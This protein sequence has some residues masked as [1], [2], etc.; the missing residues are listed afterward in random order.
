[1]LHGKENKGGSQAIMNPGFNHVLRP[2]GP[3]QEIEKTSIRT[4]LLDLPELLPG[5]GRLIRN[6]GVKGR[7]K[8]GVRT[9]F[10]E[11]LFDSRKRLAER[12]REVRENFRHRCLACVDHGVSFLRE[13]M[14]IFGSGHARVRRYVW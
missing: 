14:L 3:Y 7:K 4:Q 9:Q 5:K 6:Y 12:F 2:G 10:V 11:P 8:G 1:M 13:R